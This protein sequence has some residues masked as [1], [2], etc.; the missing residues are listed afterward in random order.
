MLVL[1]EWMYARSSRDYRWPSGRMGTSTVIPRPIDINSY[2]SQELKL[3]WLWERIATVVFRDVLLAHNRVAEHPSDRSHAQPAT[4]SM[5]S[6]KSG[7]RRPV[8]TV[9]TTFATNDAPYGI[10][11]DDFDKLAKDFAKRLG[12]KVEAR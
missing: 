5:P 12:L 10:N 8:V 9:G 11:P 4:F 3:E 7:D 6:R 1:G 2:S